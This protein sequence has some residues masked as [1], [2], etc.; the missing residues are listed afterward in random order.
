MSKTIYYV[1]LQRQGQAPSK[2]KFAID[3]AKKMV[4]EVRQ[5]LKG[6]LLQ[7]KAVEDTHDLVLRDSQLF[8][9]CSDD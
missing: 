9:L 4:K 2:F 5:E 7:K 8:E 1:E 6:K 3:G